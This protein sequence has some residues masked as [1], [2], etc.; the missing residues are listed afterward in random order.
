MTTVDYIRGV[1]SAGWAPFPKRLWQRNYWERIVRNESELQRIRTYVETNPLRGM[2]M[3]RIEAPNMGRVSDEFFQHDL[4]GLQRIL[5]DA[6]VH[7]PI[8]NHIGRLSA[9]D[10]SLMI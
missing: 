3:D 7:S 1:R 2:R 5:M 4:A 10:A 9:L 8:P 6:S